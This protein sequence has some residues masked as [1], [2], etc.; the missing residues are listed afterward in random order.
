MVT[1]RATFSMSLFCARVSG[2]SDPCDPNVKS[3]AAKTAMRIKLAFFISLVSW[4][5]LVDEA[6]PEVYHEPNPA[7]HP[8]FFSVFQAAALFSFSSSLPINPFHGGTT[9]VT[10]PEAFN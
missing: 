3:S 7:G 5:A 2:R 1:D 8:L 9:S 10:L 4:Q 6:E